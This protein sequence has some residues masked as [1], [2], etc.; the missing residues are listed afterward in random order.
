LDSNE[1][2]LL[3]IAE[4]WAA[5]AQRKF[6]MSTTAA[7]Q[8]VSAA[9]QKQIEL[10]AE[11]EQLLADTLGLSPAV[12]HESRHSWLSGPKS[13]GQYVLGLAESQ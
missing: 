8:T 10:K 1:S 5:M 4:K 6:D 9:E 13:A 7:A 12:R 11:I 2:E 3:S